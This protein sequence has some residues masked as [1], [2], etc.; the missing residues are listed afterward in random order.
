MDDLVTCI[1]VDNPQAIDPINLLLDNQDIHIEDLLVPSTKIEF[2]LYRYVVMYFTINGDVY[3][4]VQKRLKRQGGKVGYLVLGNRLSFTY[5]DWKV[6]GVSAQQNQMT[7]RIALNNYLWN[8]ER[9]FEEIARELL[10]Q[11]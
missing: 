10:G 7:Y 2:E 3:D 11:T 8:D 5:N 4:L 1:V 9:S 6:A